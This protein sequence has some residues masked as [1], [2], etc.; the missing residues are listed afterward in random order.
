M[1]MFHNFMWD[2]RRNNRAFKGDAMLITIQLDEG[3]NME[4]GNQQKY[5]CYWALLQKHEFMSW[6][7]HEH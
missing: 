4:A 6:R 5:I 2:V 1:P 3:T 7:S